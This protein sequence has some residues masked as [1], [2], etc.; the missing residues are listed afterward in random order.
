MAVWSLTGSIGALLLLAQG[1]TTSD[2][3][4]VTAVAES[5]AFRATVFA[6]ASQVPAP[7]AISIDDRGVV[8]TA[9]SLRSAGHGHFDVRAWRGILPDDLRLGSVAERRTATE[10]WVRSGLLDRPGEPVTLAG[11][12]RHSEQVRRLVDRD[13]DGV[14]DDAGVW[15]AGM[16][17]LERGALAGVLAWGR[18]QVYATA[19]PELV[20]WRDSLGAARGRRVLQAGFGV[21]MGQGGHDMHGLTMGLDGRLY[22]SIGDRGFALTTRDGRRLAA[23]EGAVFRCWPDGSG[24]ELFARGLRNPQELAFDDHGDLFTGD[25]NA[26]VGDRSRWLYLP[27]GAHGGWEYYLQ[28]TASCGPWLREHESEPAFPNGDP[29]QPAWVLHPVAEAGS[30]PAGLAA[31]PGTGLPPRY[32]GTLWLADFVGGV[33]AWRFV[34]DG[35]GMK[36]AAKLPGHHRSWGTCDVDFAPD[37]RLFVLYWGESWQPSDRA[38]L[39]ALTPAW[40]LARGTGADSVHLNAE[41]FADER[42]AR[43]ALVLVES[44]RELLARGVRELDDT[45]LAALLSHPDRRLRQRAS[46]ELG[47]RGRVDALTHVLVTAGEPR[48]RLHALWGL[49]IA[50]HGGQGAR[51]RER[52]AAALAQPDPE[53][54]RLAAM[55]LGELGA[56]EAVPALSMLLADP[57]PRVRFAAGQ[58][59]ARCGDARAVPS[60]LSALAANADS[61]AFLRFS[62]ARALARA[63]DTLTLAGLHAHADRSVRLGAVL[64][65]REA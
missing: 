21:H 18:D 55:L 57:A 29:A 32:D 26:D 2:T 51:V 58:A 49:N 60:L 15:A 40:R 59:L 56:V 23:H 44:T 19:I 11:L 65:L 35:A 52:F 53:V 27:E 4:N 22:W 43:E 34:P 61:D 25:N 37:G 42:E 39:L 36:L 24:L 14:A 46:L 13:G 50:A 31:Y 47:R 20:S 48:A 10:R 54:R 8:Y 3:S 28:F 5:L 45:R 63:A 1:R 12:A 33:D 62:Y 17:E 9:N 64:A 41:G 38:R 16:N 30:C 7:V 6:T